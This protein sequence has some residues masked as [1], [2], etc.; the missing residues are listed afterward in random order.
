MSYTLGP[1]WYRYKYTWKNGTLKRA[2]RFGTVYKVSSFGKQN[3]IF[4]A[5]KSITVYDSASAENI[6]FILR[7]GNGVLVDKIRSNSNGTM[8]R[9]KHRG[10]VGWIKYAES[11]LD[12]NLPV[13]SN[14]SYAG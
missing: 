10:R 3:K 2:D 13:F 1:S 7:K 9:I 11:S 14:V 12:S 8:L 4:K 6:A 5:A